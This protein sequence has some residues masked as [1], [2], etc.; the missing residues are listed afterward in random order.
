MKSILLMS[1]F[2]MVSSL[3]TSCTTE[4]IET[5]KTKLFEEVTATGGDESG[6]I[7]TRKPQ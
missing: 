4:E 6:Q 5:T 7:P 3:I 1:C 2:I